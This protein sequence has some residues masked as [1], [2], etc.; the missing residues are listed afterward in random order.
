MLAAFFTLAAQSPTRQRSFR[1]AVVAHVL[2][3]AAVG[4]LLCR[5]GPGSSAP[6]ALLGH[7]LLVAGIV[8]GGLLVGW[9]LTQLPKSQ[10]LEFVL[11]S[12]LSAHQL[13]LSEALVGLAQL[14][15]ITLSGL[16][17]LSLLAAIGYFAPLDLVP[18]VALPFVWGA[19]TGL[20]LAMWA[21]E[22]QSV[23]RWG[24]RVA[25]LLILVYLVVGV[26]AAEKLQTWLECLPQ[27]LSVMLLRGLV[28][29]HTHNPFGA[30][31][32][33]LTVGGETG[34]ERVTAI[35]LIG[36]GLAIGFLIRASRRLHGHFHE[37]HYAPAE[38]DF[39]TD[40]PAVGERP[41]SWW[42]VRRVARFSGRSNLW[43]AGG[44]GILYALYVVA[45]EH[46]PAWMGT[47]AFELCDRVAGIPGLITALVLLAAVPAA[48]QYGL[49]DSSDQDR[50]KRLE[51]L[52]LTEL[53]ASDY[54]NAAAAA[55]WERGRGY[56]AVAALLALTGVAGGRMDLGQFAA[57]VA[58]ALL[59]WSLYFAL[60]FRGF[61]RGR[62]AGGLGLLLTVGLPLLVLGL[63]SLGWD[64]LAAILP[65][66]ALHAA[67]TTSPSPALLIGPLLAALIALV[68]TRQTLAS[69]D[70][71]LRVWYD[72]HSGRKVLA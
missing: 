9:R 71:D 57:T 3:L 14:F 49:W 69:C 5:T 58:A 70:A 44:F 59:L 10:S 7:V 68:I 39:S 31:Q 19:V 53:R 36:L 12:P 22:P 18:L 8:E 45:G 46:W 25:M 41:L 61:A 65:P 29:L 24:E 32:H 60:G 62:Q 51:L 17:L 42:A 38:V 63:R 52:L 4:G 6:V 1:R 43:L 72:R 26:L 27:G 15:L 11:V 16:P 20:G 23:R 50:C 54:W 33:A 30:M 47:R 67:G 66:G 56:F 28:R 21:Y 40:R 13:F 48:Y 2:L 34:R 55:A 35:G 37:W 64:R